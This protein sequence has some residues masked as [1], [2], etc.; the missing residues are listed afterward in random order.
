[1]QHQITQSRASFVYC[2]FE[3][4]IYYSIVFRVSFFL[5]ISNLSVKFKHFKSIT[6]TLETMNVLLSRTNIFCRN[7][8]LP[9]V[10]HKCSYRKYKNEHCH[11]NVYFVH[12]DISSVLKRFRKITYTTLSKWLLSLTFFQLQLEW[13]EG[14]K[15]SL[16]TLVASKAIKTFKQIGKKRE[17]SNITLSIKPVLIPPRKML[18][19]WSTMCIAHEM[20]QC[21]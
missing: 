10:K 19:G 12:H 2:N 17:T 6:N 3:T 21:L 20:E 8:Q 14:N 13:S 15:Y 1:M 9:S 5:T 7:W 11:N 16:E 18:R 4:S